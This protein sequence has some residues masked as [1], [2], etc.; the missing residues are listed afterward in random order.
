MPEDKTVSFPWAAFGVQVMPTPPGCTGFAA[1]LK[2]GAPILAA[3][4]VDDRDKAHAHILVHTKPESGY[5]SMS[6]IDAMFIDSLG[7]EAITDGRT[8]LSPLIFAPIMAQNGIN[9]KGLA[10]HP[11]ST[12]GNLSD[13]ASGKKPQ[14]NEAIMTRVLLDKCA[15]VRECEELLKGYDP[16]AATVISGV[17]LQVT[18]AIG[19]YA[20]LCY[21][22]NELVAIRSTP[23]ASNQYECYRD[24]P[25][26]LWN[27]RITKAEELAAM[28]ADYPE[29]YD[30]F[31]KHFGVEK[32]QDFNTTYNKD[33]DDLRV[34]RRFRREDLPLR[35][36]RRV[37][38][39]KYFCSAF[40][41]K[42]ESRAV[43]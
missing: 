26:V 43:L 34:G 1:R 14:L 38:V 27:Q 5:E 17:Q 2:D 33:P 8:D 22:N 6:G 35:R 39:R 11:F 13:G 15:T 29:A 12:F 9:E 32:G 36:F 19:D 28:Y 4:Y 10:I 37:S 21:A 16:I 18:D 40:F 20:I 25:D 42:A 7:S 30:V 41:R 3:N 24:E 31:C 23:I